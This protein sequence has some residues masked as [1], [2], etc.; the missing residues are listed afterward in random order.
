MQ[1]WSKKMSGNMSR[2]KISLFIFI[3]LLLHKCV[4]ADEAPKRG[5][6]VFFTPPPIEGLTA[7]EVMEKASALEAKKNLTQAI[8]MLEA[9]LNRY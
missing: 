4:F 8:E 2:S 1:T 5:K 3:L 9:Y 6:L 7:E